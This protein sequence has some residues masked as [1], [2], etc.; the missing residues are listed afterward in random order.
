M[1]APNAA[2]STHAFRSVLFPT[3][4][5]TDGLPAFS[6]ALRLALDGRCKLTLLHVGRGRNVNWDRFPGIRDT[7]ARWEAIPPAAT[8]KDLGA[9]GIKARKM[10]LDGGNPV[11]GILQRA[12]KGDVDLLVLTTHRRVGVR[13][14]LRSSVAESVARR[15]RSPSLVLPSGGAGFVDS[16]NGAVALRR[17]LVPGAVWP[18]PEITLETVA[19]LIATLGLDA[20]V[21]RVLRVGESPEHAVPDGWPEG[22]VVEVAR[23]DGAVVDAI[24]K[25]ASTW[26]ADLVAMA[27]LGHDDTVDQ[28]RGSTTERVLRRA[29]LPVLVVPGPR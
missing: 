1:F 25:E 5:R 7:L 6:H 12:R 17:I 2:L 21:V 8:R 29:T 15:A 10:S 24:M 14:L 23:R 16:A 4:L 26:G 19:R 18:H 27:T 3:D 9:I 20:G 11:K 13:G 28:L 22:W